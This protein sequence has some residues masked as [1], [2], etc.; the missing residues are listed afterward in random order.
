MAIEGARDCAN[1]RKVSRSGFWEGVGGGGIVGG[2][3]GGGFGEGG[4]GGRGR[5]KGAEEGPRKA[6][7]V[8]G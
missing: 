2:G 4:G 7:T 8:K 6:L 1:L 3:G 5:A